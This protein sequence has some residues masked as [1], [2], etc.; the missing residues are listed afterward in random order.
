MG[1]GGGDNP[2]VQAGWGQRSDVWPSLNTMKQTHQRQLE[3]GGE[4][5][6][7]PS[8][9]AALAEHPPA[10]PS[11]SKTLKF[12][13]LC[14]SPQFGDA[15][16]CHALLPHEGSQSRA[17]IPTHGNPCKPP[18]LC[19]TSTTTNPV[20][21]EIP[22]PASPSSLPST[23]PPC[24]RQLPTPSCQL[25]LLWGFFSFSLFLPPPPQKC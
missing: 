25:C 12:V 11:P 20:W 3:Q 14:P 15:M 19:S 8:Q 4:G 5:Q 2:Q 21:Q 23:E 1:H 24:S 10:A 18:G 16:L 9:P 17:S 13:L 22:S 7:P 6:G